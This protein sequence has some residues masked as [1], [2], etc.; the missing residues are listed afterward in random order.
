TVWL[1][2][3][4]ISSHFTFN[5][6]NFADYKMLTSP[7]S[8]QMANKDAPLHIKGMGTIVLEHK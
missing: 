3:S 4:G 5:L 2:D 8:I 1:F 7:I 6:N